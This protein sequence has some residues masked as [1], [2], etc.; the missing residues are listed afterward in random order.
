MTEKERKAAA[1]K[2]FQVLEDA[3]DKVDAENVAVATKVIILRK[4]VGDRDPRFN[5]RGTFKVMALAEQIEGACRFLSASHRLSSDFF[6]T[7]KPTNSRNS[8]RW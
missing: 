1:S 3:V 7:E 8:S 2:A 5:L 6:G 4:F